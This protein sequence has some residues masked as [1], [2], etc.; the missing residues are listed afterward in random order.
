LPVKLSSRAVADGWRGVVKS[1][2]QKVESAKLERYLETRFSTEKASG[3]WFL[4]PLFA[5]A[6]AVLFLLGMRAWWKTR[7]KHEERHGRR[8]KGPEVVIAVCGTR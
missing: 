6:A 3:G 2:P 5:C 8:T 1:E 7:S 4:Q